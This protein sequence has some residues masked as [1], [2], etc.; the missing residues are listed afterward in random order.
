MTRRA[1]GFGTDGV[2][3]VANEELTAFVALKLGMAAAYVLTHHVQRAQVVVGRDT[4]ISGDMLEGALAAGL[5]S[6]GVRVQNVGIVPTPGVAYITTKMGASAGAVISASHNPYDDNGIKFFGPDGRKLSDA[7]EDEIE[8]AMRR[9]H[10]LP[11][12]K[13][14][15]IGRVE[16][17]P[18]YVDAYLAFLHTRS[19][20]PLHGFHLV[21]DCANGAT[22][23]IAPRVFS[24]LGARI[25]AIHTQPSGTNI[26]LDC[27]STHPSSLCQTVREVGADAGLAFDGDGDRVMM[28]DERGEVVDG[29]QMMALC[30]IAMRQRGELSND[31]VVATVMSNAGLDVAMERH[32]IRLIRTA[33]GDRYVAEALEATGAALGGEQSGHLLFPRV[34]RAGDGIITGLRVLAEMK[35]SGLRLSQLAAVMERLPQKLRN[36][37]VH[38][39]DGWEEGPGVREAIERA[40]ERL[41]RRE[42]LS[43]RASGTEPVIRIMA[44]GPD[45]SVVD[46]VVD[47]LA[48]VIAAAAR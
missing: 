19:P 30:A 7:L 9:W 13:G 31:T 42:W 29:D 40:Y 18:E 32:G 22:C 48:S 45:A 1:I 25:T 21:L 34:S 2:R 27:G 4:R 6:M 10:R 15:Q 5:A 47:D 16:D 33:V 12:P 43:V 17:H 23:S 36:V 28:C 11:R 20:F 46:E 39:R 3:G 26:N 35:R 8:R 44:Q 38:H 37:R 41:G 24:D 14:G